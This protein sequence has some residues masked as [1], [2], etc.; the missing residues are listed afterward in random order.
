MFILVLKC[1]H[2]FQ[3]HS[4]LNSDFDDVDYQQ[5]ICIISIIDLNTAVCVNNLVVLCK[6]RV[7][8][9][10]SHAHILPYTVLAYDIIHKKYVLLYSVLQMSTDLYVLFQESNIYRIPTG[11]AVNEEEK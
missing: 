4:E 7:L 1:L 5:I 11:M 8:A 2:S 3:L 10:Q 9:E 6:Y